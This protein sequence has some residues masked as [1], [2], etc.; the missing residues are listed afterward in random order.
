MINTVYMIS[1]RKAAAAKK[2]KKRKDN[3]KNL[4]YET[5]NVFLFSISP[6]ILFAQRANRFL[7]FMWFA[8]QANRTP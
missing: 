2:A 7:F 3:A 4:T 1:E 5:T 8:Q 6:F